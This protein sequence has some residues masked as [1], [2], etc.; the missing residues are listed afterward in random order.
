MSAVLKPK[1]QDVAASLRQVVGD[2]YVIDAAAELEFYS[3]D[4]YGPAE[5]AVLVVQPQTTEQVADVV[6]VVTGADFNLVTRGGGM[7]YTGGYT[8]A[9]PNTVIVDTQ[10]LN[11]ILEINPDDMIITVEAGVTWHQIYEK[12][13]PMGL[14]LPFFGT[15]SGRKA[16]VG[17]GLANGALFMGTARYGTIAEIGGGG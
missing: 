16:T 7:S 2:E 15:Y 11:R 12:L 4:V 17:G 9:K 8:P 6:K 13:K 14:R 3:T 5:T 1:I 10:S